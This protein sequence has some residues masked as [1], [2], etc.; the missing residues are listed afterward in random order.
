ADGV[1]FHVEATRDARALA[2]AI[3]ARRKKAGVALKPRTP[4]SAVLELLEHVDMV[5]VMTVEPGFGGQRFMRDQVEK[6]RAIAR[7]AVSLGVRIEVDGGLDPETVREAASAGA[8]VI[9]AGNA[10]F[11]APDPARV[12]EELRK[13]GSDSWG[14]SL[15]P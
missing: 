7:K 15:G 4:A 6:V 3:R 13:N 2:H 14:S 1:T 10:V 12:I 9:V 8:S 5:L 11:R